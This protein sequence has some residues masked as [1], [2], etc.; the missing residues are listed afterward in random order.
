MFDAQH[1]PDG[2]MHARSVI[3]TTPSAGGGGGGQAMTGTVKSYNPNKGYGFFSAE[4]LGEDVFFSGDR[5]PQEAA[6]ARLENTVAVFNVQQKADGKYEATNIQLSGNFARGPGMGDKRQ[7]SQFGGGGGND[8]FAKRPRTSM[9]VQ[10]QPMQHVQPLVENTLYSGTIKSFREQTNYGFIMSPHAVGDLRFHCNDVVNGTD[11]TIEQ[12]QEV[13][14]YARSSPD[15]RLQAY[16]V[17]IM[18]D[19]KK[20]AMR[21]KREN[22]D[23]GT[24]LE[25]IRE[26]LPTLGPQELIKM[27]LL[28]GQMMLGHS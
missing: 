9:V 3:T 11:V 27:H 24:A 16:N 4:G 21:K 12:T 26:L 2:K 28:V 13:T 10:H 14:F 19:G 7:F 15:G 8:H 23:A 17:T 5:I 6:G 18:V 25:S 1:M 22:I 20:P